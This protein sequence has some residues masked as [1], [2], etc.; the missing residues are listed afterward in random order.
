MSDAA[1]LRRL[2]WR[3]RRGMRELDQLLEGYLDKRWP[4]A[5]PLERNGFERLL[6]CEDDQLWRWFL[7]HSRPDDPELDAAVAHVL[8]AAH[9]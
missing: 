3:C 7:H 5:E 4:N 9:V 6:D 2:R 1:G 8:A